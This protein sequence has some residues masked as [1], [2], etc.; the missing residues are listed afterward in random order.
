MLHRF[1]L[2]YRPHLPLFFLDFFC[3]VLMSGLALVFPL[4]VRQVID[5]ILPAGGCLYLFCCGLPWCETN[6]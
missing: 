1:A 4:A 6:N 2:Y 5:D 3:A